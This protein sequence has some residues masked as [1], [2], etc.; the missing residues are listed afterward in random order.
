MYLHEY[1]AKELLRKWGIFIP[2]FAIASNSDEVKKALFDL[3]LSEAVIKAQVHAGGRAKAGGVQI[4]KGKEAIILAAKEMIGLRIVNEQTGKNGKVVHQVLITAPV[5]VQKEYYIALLIDFKV[6]EPYILVSKEAGIDVEEKMQKDPNSFLKVYFS[7]DGKVTA[8]DLEKIGLFM[9]W[10]DDLRDIGCQFITQLADAFISMDATLLEINPLALT[11]ENKLIP[12][13][14]KLSI[15]DNAL[16]RHEELQALYD[17]SQFTTR[18]VL[19]NMHNFSY[20]PLQGD[21][22]CMVNGA[23]LAMATMD[24]IDYFGGSPANF[25][26][27]GGSATKDRVAEGF[28]ILIKD[29]KVRAIL[30]NIFGGIMDCMVIAEGIIQALKEL[31]VGL[32]KKQKSIP[33]IVRMEGTNR[34]K[35]CY[36]LAQSKFNVTIADGLEDAAKK[37]V[38]AAGI[39]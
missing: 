31:Y 30:V 26:D 17:P 7:L 22:G 2:E 27:I 29:A 35:G 5:V 21:I 1:Q 4:V 15:D 25:L 12:L 20:V 11:E 28:K 14:V 3:K 24:I 38:I 23:G 18:E 34:D 33:I 36:L 6:A 39:L 37:A 16:F 9:G 13:D 10:Q 8:S 32:V 19:A